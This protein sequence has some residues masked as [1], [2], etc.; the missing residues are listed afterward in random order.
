MATNAELE[1]TRLKRMLKRLRERYRG[2]K[3]TILVGCHKG[4]KCLIE[5]VTVLHYKVHFMVKVYKSEKE[6]EF[7]KDR[8]QMYRDEE[9]R[10]PRGPSHPVG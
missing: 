3:A 5:D 6:N 1:E 9:L 7:I 2:K 8:T 4:Q 10:I